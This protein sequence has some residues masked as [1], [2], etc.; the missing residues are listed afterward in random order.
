MTKGLITI[1]QPFGLELCLF[2]P[3]DKKLFMK[4]I[5]LPYFYN[6]PKIGVSLWRKNIARARVCVC[7]SAYVRKKKWERTSGLQMA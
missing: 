4:S 2:Y 1:P 6:M 3:Q 5:I 7:V